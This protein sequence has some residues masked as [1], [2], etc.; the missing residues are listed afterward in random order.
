MGSYPPGRLPSAVTWPVSFKAGP[1]S[2]WRPP[3]GGPGWVPAHTTGPA[4]PGALLRSSE[5]AGRAG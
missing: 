3:Q 5:L 4:K 1:Q 2:R